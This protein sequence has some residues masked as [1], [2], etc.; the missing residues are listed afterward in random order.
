MNLI[1]LYKRC[2]RIGKI[3]FTTKINVAAGLFF[4]LYI[5]SSFLKFVYLLLH[6]S[7]EAFSNQNY[8]KMKF[9]SSRRESNPYEPPIA[10]W[11]EI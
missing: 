3:Y 9:L 7:E 8:S 10:H 5:V 2:M 6:V 11:L 4:D 1:K